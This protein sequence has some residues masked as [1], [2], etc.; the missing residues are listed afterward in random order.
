M[1]EVLTASCC[2]SD[3]VRHKIESVLEG[4]KHEIP[5][6]SWSL[7][8]IAEHPELSVKYEAPITPAIIVDGKLEFLGFPKK[9]ALEAKIRE[10]AGKQLETP[11]SAEPSNIRGRV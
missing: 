4:L 2:T 5:E 3:E 9:P 6:L 11:V 8:D 7:I 10:Y 1:V